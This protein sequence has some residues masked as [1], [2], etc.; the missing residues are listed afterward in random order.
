D[1]AV[2]RRRASAGACVM[3]LRFTGDRLVPDARF[4]RLRAELG[5]NFLAIEIDSLPGNSHGISRLAHSVLTEDF[6]DEPDHPTRRAA[7][8]VIAFYRRQLL[9]A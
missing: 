8:A 3:G 1:L 4:A 5:D 2:I 6:V 9:P 7:D